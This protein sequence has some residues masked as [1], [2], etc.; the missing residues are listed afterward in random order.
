MFQKE[1]VS[2]Y[3]GKTEIAQLQP[4]KEVSWVSSRKSTEKPFRLYGRGSK[5]EKMSS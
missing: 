4:R 2:A 5:S 1:E 3:P